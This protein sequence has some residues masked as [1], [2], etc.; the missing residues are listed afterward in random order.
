[1]TQ[2]RFFKVESVAAAAG[3]MR[4]KIWFRLQW[5]D[6][7]LSWNESE[8]GGITQMWMNEI[9]GSS[10][11]GALEI[12]VPDLTP[13][14]T[15]DPIVRSL[16]PVQAL[17]Y[18]NGRVFWSRP[19]ILDIMCKFS[20]LSAFPFDAMQCGIDVGG[21]MISGGYQGIELMGGGYQFSNQEPTAGTS[22]QEYSI[23]KVEAK[24]ENYFYACCPSEPWPV[25]NY[26]ITLR[27][28][29]QY[30]MSTILLPCITLT[31]LSFCVFW[32]SFEVGERLGFGITIVLALE[33]TKVVIYT[34]VPVCGETL[35]V[36]TFLMGSTC[37]AMVALAETCFALFLA[38]HVD[39]HIL[40][41]WM[42]P[43][44]FVTVQICWLLGMPP[45]SVKSK[46]K[47]ISY[48]SALVM[49]CASVNRWDVATAAQEHT[50]R[51]R[52]RQAGQS[53]GPTTEPC[54]PNNSSPP[55]V[56][57]EQ[58][59]EKPQNINTSSALKVMAQRRP[60]TPAD[61]YRFVFF[62]KLFFIIDS[63]SNGYVLIHEMD[64]L[65]QFLSHDK[66]EKERARVLHALDDE[67]DGLIQQVSFHANELLARMSCP[68][69]PFTKFQ[70]V[71][72]CDA[73]RTG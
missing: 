27:R 34:Y 8:F 72:C 20:G 2:I 6:S 24:I 32:M 47:T 1:M 26:V 43:P 42:M 61:G 11:N 66:D 69:M 60:L 21:W 65:L 22:Y 36:D 18:S 50:R 19:G 35:W 40:P 33:V 46:D 55:F 23:R 3:A 5:T 14:N 48:V 41:V 53:T 38:Y 16:E 45:P 63:D 56:L 51:H 9:D 37:F 30:Y 13:Y 58:Y 7:R 59:G 52:F 71:L 4:L 31:L 70:M 62:E 17:V 12:W 10:E 64:R 29:T 39:D 68:W 67:K 15:R 25:I 57:R 49:E 73:H 54:A 44:R 28:A